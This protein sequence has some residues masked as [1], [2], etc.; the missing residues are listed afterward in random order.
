MV[1]IQNWILIPCTYVYILHLLYTVF[2]WNI[3]D[4]IF[5]VFI[6]WYDGVMSENH[7]QVRLVY[8][9]K[10]REFARECLQSEE[11][12]PQIPYFFIDAK[13]ADFSSFDMNTK[14][15]IA[16]IHAFASGNVPL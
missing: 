4:S 12:N 15:E 11:A 8:A 3:W 13:N 6:R 16:S 7:K 14:N 5:L 1:K 10:I 2:H 9:E